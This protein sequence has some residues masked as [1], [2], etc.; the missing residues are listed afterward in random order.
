LFGNSIDYV[1]PVTATDVNGKPIVEDADA[2]SVAISLLGGAYVAYRQTAGPNSPLGGPRIF[3]N[4]LSDG[5]SESGAEFKGAFVADPNVSGGDEAKLGPPS[6]DIDEH[7]DLRLI[8]DSNGVPQVVEGNDRGLSATLSL[9]PDFDGL[10]EPSASV[11]NPSG[12]GISAWVSKTPLGA[13]AVAVR[14]DF[15]EGAVQTALVDGGGVA[16]DSATGYSR[17]SRA[18]S[19]TQRSW[20]PRRA[21]L[22]PN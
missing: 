14:E 7:E 13:P 9:G 10:E 5:E 2:P 11:M 4:K 19:A 20:R 21:R 18:C 3:L 8:Y 16:P 15:P 12:G 1:L 17:S 6:I 22:P